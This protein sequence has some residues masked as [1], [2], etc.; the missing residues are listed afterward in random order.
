MADIFNYVDDNTMG[1]DSIN[2]MM[3]ALYIM[4]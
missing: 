3:Y 4:L 2:S 1:A